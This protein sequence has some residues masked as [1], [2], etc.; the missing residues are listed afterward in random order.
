MNIDNSLIKLTRK[1]LVQF[2]CDTQVLLCHLH[3][4]GCHIEHTCLSAVCPFCHAC[5]LFCGTTISRSLKLDTGSLVYHA[6]AFS[7]NCVWYNFFLLFGKESHLT[8]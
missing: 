5:L 1:R 7:F 3:K 6:H 2:I 8:H 4:A